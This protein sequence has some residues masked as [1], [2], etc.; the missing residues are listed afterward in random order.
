MRPPGTTTM[1]SG[2]LRVNLLLHCQLKAGSRNCGARN[3][4]QR[5]IMEHF[6]NEPWSG[7]RHHEADID[8]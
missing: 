3:I 2:G 8:A 1:V 7:G 5:G 4:A 6:A